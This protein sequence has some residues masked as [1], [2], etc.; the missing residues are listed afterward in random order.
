M[1]QDIDVTLCA[2]RKSYRLLYDYHKRIQSLIDQIAENLDV[3]FYRWSSHISNPKGSSDL[4]NR[5]TWDAFPQFEYM[6]LFAKNIDEIDSPKAGNALIELRVE[7]DNSIFSQD[8]DNEPNPH[9]VEAEQAK[10]QIIAY[11]WVCVDMPKGAT[12]SLYAIWNYSDYPESE[13]KFEGI[14]TEYGE[15]KALKIT[16]EMSALATENDIRK[17]SDQIQKVLEGQPN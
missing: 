2:V 17:F 1:T 13:M 12:E 3:T 5:W 8:G 9:L 10:T 16:K 6:V 11:V 14:E 15:F 7:T 4:R